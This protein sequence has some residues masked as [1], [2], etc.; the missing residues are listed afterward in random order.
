MDAMRSHDLFLPILD[1][2]IQQCN[3]LFLKIAFDKLPWTRKYINQ[4]EKLERLGVD[5][6]HQG[7]FDH[8]KSQ[9]IYRKPEE[10]I[11]L[12]DF[13]GDSESAIHICEELS[14]KLR[15]IKTSNF[16]ITKYK[17]FGDILYKLFGHWKRDNRIH[18]SI[19]TYGNLSNMMFHSNKHT[20]VD[21]SG[22]KLNISTNFMLQYTFFKMFSEHRFD[23]LKEFDIR[24][25]AKFL[26]TYAE[27][28]L[29]D[30]VVIDRLLSDMDS[31]EGN[32]DITLP[33]YY[34]ELFARIKDKL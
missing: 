15:S 3:F 25:Y 12:L 32:D 21:K 10:I 7:Y 26:M 9:V 2:W 22:K 34:P 31:F 16:F 5:T 27:R 23:E 1:L 29:D 17:V 4:K 30:K 11:R 24:V 28:N 19:K 14:D 20:L 8:L 6:F 18:S 33:F 13:T